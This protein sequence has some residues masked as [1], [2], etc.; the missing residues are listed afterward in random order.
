[1]LDDGEITACKFCGAQDV[2]EEKKE[3]VILDNVKDLPHC[4][5]NV[6]HKWKV[7][8]KEDH[9]HFKCEYCPTDI[10]LEKGADLPPTLAPE[11]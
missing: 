5:S 1:M 2:E 11:E 6:G 3:A 10:K 9:D 7:Y 4:T 8:H